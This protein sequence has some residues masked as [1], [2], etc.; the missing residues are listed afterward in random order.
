MFLF[1]LSTTQLSI[2]SPTVYQQADKD[3]YVY[4]RRSLTV[5]VPASTAESQQGQGVLVG[6][7]LAENERIEPE[8][9]L[10]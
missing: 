10:F 8:C 4:N 9:K 5:P 1:S 7:E 2:Y 6:G 3:I